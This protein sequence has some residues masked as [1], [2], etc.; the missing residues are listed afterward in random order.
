MFASA[1]YAPE[2]RRN[3]R[4]E[5]GDE[6]P[7]HALEVV[8]LRLLREDGPRRLGGRR[9][10]LPEQGDVAEDDLAALVLVDGHGVAPAACFAWPC[11]TSARE[12]GRAALRALDAAL[13]PVLEEERV[14]VALAGEDL[15]R[16]RELRLRDDD[17]VPGRGADRDGLTRRKHA[18]LDDL[19]ALDHPDAED[20]SLL[21][22]H[23]ASLLLAPLERALLHSALHLRQERL[24]AIE[25]SVA[26]V[27][28]GHEEHRLG[29]L[30]SGPPPSAPRRG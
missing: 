6:Q 4:A 5:D 29:L 28:P 30:E 14:P 2:W 9:D 12:V 11:E 26:Q 24:G 23:R 1:T 18:L 3:D 17:R 13:R 16:R 15:E 19:A 21:S 22:R 20:L 8:A 10:E 7:V 25:V 27:R